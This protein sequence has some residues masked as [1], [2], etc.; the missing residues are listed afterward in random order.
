MTEQKTC[1]VIAPIGEHDSAVRKRSDEIL[2]FVIRPP[3]DEYGYRAERADEIGKSGIITHQIIERVVKEPLVIADLTDHNPNVFYELAV[4]HASRKPCILIIQAG[5]P[6]PFDINQN[7]VIKVDHHELTSVHAA[8]QEIT[9][10][11]KDFEEHPTSTDTPI[12]VTLDLQ[13]L[14]GSDRSQ[15]QVLVNLTEIILAMSS[16]VQGLSDQLHDPATLLPPG[17]LQAILG[18]SGNLRRIVPPELMDETAKLLI[19]LSDHNPASGPLSDE[20]TTRSKLIARMMREIATFL[21]MA[22]AARVVSA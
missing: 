2:E 16:Q 11:I 7:R 1:F 13:L 12:S 5:Q 19:L 8:K 20:V 6:I 4:R 10:Q 21:R 15:E 9:K 14:R 18:D 3:L 17:Y 22:S